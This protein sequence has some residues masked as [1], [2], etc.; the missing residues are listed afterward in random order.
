MRA[1]FSGAP[2]ESIVYL[3]HP[4]TFD[5]RKASELLARHS[6]RVPHFQDYAGPVVQFF[7]EHEDDPSFVPA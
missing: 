2:R 5:T 4:V 6:M 3:N 7:R 1:Y